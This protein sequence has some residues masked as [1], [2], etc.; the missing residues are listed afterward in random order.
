[1]ISIPNFGAMRMSSKVLDSFKLDLEHRKLAGSI[2]VGEFGKI[3]IYTDG[4]MPDNIV[5][6]ENNGKI[7][8]I[9]RIGE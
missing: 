3:D 1:M 8:G 5:A 7:V 9:I 4:L 2:D 6:L